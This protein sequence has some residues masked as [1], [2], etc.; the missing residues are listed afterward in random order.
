M[1]GWV[2]LQRL[3][4]QQLQ[5]RD[6]EGC[7]CAAVLVSVLVRFSLMAMM[8]GRPMEIA[9]V[10][11]QPRTTLKTRPFDGQ[12]IALTHHSS[13]FYAAST[14]QPAFLLRISSQPRPLDHARTSSLSPWDTS[15]SGI[16]ISADRARDSLDITVPIGTC[17]I[18]AMSL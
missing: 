11:R 6:V 12:E 10:E 7:R 16:R 1:M 8:A 14:P 17:V 3:T 5:H 2:L 15:A 9:V 18:R 4:S 13:D